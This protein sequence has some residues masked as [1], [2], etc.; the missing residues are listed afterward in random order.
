MCL[1]CSLLRDPLNSDNIF[2]CDN[3]NLMFLKRALALAKHYTSTIKHISNRL[4]A[5]HRVSQFGRN[6][7]RSSPIMLFVASTIATCIEDTG[8]N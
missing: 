2:I 5:R 6:L 3:Y 1:K 4:L 8:D 7:I